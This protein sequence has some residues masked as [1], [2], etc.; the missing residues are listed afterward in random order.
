M[1]QWVEYNS[2]P[3]HFVCYH[4]GRSAIPA[5]VLLSDTDTPVS[6]GLE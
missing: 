1:Q 2:N 3:N 6:F 4:K 5:L